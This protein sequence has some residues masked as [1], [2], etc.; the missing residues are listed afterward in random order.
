[1]ASI[2]NSTT[3]N[4]VTYFVAFVP[5]VTIQGQ[6]V[7]VCFDLRNALTLL[8]IIYYFVSLLTS[9]FPPVIAVGFNLLFVF[10]EPFSVRML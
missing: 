2:N 5:S 9:D 1:M 3:T 6:T 10:L 8:S 4:L 7:S